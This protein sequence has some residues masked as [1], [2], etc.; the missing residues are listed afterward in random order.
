M[1]GI[2]VALV[3][4]VVLGAPSGTGAQAVG[5]PMCVRQPPDEKVR[6]I[7]RYIADR[8]EFGF[9]ADE[10]YVR[11]L[12]RGGLWHYD[13]W[14]PV[15]PREKVYLHFRDRLH[16]G[17]AARRYLRRHEDLDGGTSVKD[18]WPHEPY[19][20]QRLTRHRAKHTA[21]LERLARFPDNL[22][23]RIVPLSYRQ[24]ERIESAIH[25]RGRDADGFRLAASWIDIRHTLVHIQLITTRPDHQAYFRERYGPH[26]RTYVV[27]TELTT[28]ECTALNGWRPGATPTEIEVWWDAGGKGVFVAAEV[29]ELPDRVEVAVV[30][31]YATG[32]RTADSRPTPHTITLAAPLGDRPLISTTTGQRLRRYE[33][34]VPPMPA[35]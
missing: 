35:P 15:S 20:L 31:E 2:A 4:L 10:A 30:A 18:N 7:D 14:F 9:R 34:F 28:R 16:L 8:E 22:R 13:H 29:L 32:P 5:E 33:P 25:R 1:I 27:G 6:A 3:A 19:L 26:V 11:K 24:L 21:A 17:D 23:T 12:L